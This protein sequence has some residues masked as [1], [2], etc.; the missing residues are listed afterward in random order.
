MMIK[1]KYKLLKLK[2]ETVDE[3]IRLRNQTGRASID[4]LIISM[5]QL[6]EKNRLEMM[7]HGWQTYTGNTVVGG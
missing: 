1:R 5:I 4:D 7:N 3:L 2:A 6:A